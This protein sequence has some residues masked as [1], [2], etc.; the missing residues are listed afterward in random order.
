MPG[1]YMILAAMLAIARPCLAQKIYGLDRIYFRPVHIDAVTPAPG[2][3][4]EESFSSRGRSADLHSRE[5][6]PR[7]SRSVH[8]FLVCTDSRGRNTWIREIVD[9]QQPRIAKT[10]WKVF[11]GQKQTCEWYFMMDPAED[12]NKLLS[13]YEIDSILPVKG[14]ILTIRLKGE[15]FRPQGAWWIKG[16]TLSFNRSDSG[17]VLSCVFRLIRPGVP[18]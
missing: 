17:F 6:E 1:R 12:D 3:Y 7:N 15:M 2:V 16:L 5:S 8:D 11:V 18:E 9:R 13:N 14:S 4:G 10:C